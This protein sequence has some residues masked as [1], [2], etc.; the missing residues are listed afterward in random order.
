MK[1]NVG[2]DLSVQGVRYLVLGSI[3]Y[4]DNASGDEWEEYRLRNHDDGSESW[5]SMD[6][7]NQEYEM[8]F[9]VNTSKAPDGF[10][11]VDSGTQVVRGRAGDVDVDM[12][13][14]AQYETWED[15]SEEHTYSVERWSD[16]AEYSRGMYV[17]LDDIKDLGPSPDA[18]KAKS[19]LFASGSALV[20][21][22]IVAVT[23]FVGLLVAMDNPS[24]T[25]VAKLLSGSGQYTLVEEAAGD[26]DDVVVYTT[27]KSVDAASKDIIKRL[28]GEVESVQEDEDGTTV[29]L[30]TK[31]EYILVYEDAGEDGLDDEDDAQAGDEQQE[32]A[33]GTEGTD[34]EAEEQNAGVEEAGAAEDTATDEDASAQTASEATKG[35]LGRTLV[36]ITSR[37]HAYTTDERPYRSRYRAYRWYRA[38]YHAKAYKEDAKTYQTDES[39]YSGY[40][41]ETA[42]DSSTTSDYESYA[43]TIRQESAAAKKTSGGGTSSGK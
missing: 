23:A 20:G 19:S 5:L 32:E 22:L 35:E 7:G 21:L 37:R 12:G 31:N 6:E 18:K 13:E 43:R 27:T 28:E 38:F 29:A 41:G 1:Y 3:L 9:M 25:D 39:S 14:T 11:L 10:R 33:T 15:A 30:L 34:A 4:K 40:K 2:N 8:S 42:V 16:G 36:Q 17:S 26:S 24:K